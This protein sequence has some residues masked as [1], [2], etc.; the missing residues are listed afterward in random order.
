MEIIV[1]NAAHK[2]EQKFVFGLYVVEAP[3]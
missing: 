3:N 1:G 2:G